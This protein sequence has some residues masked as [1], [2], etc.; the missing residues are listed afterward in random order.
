MLYTTLQNMR[1]CPQALPHAVAGRAF[2]RM[3]PPSC[4]AF[5]FRCRRRPSPQRIAPC[6]PLRHKSAHQP[7]RDFAV[8]HMLMLAPAADDFRSGGS[9]AYASE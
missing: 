7:A 5:H 1:Q 6:R 4:A 2:F 3:S 8:V 9:R